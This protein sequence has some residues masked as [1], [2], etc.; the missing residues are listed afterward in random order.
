MEATGQPRSAFTVRLGAAD[1]AAAFL[2]GLRWSVTDP[3]LRW[4]VAASLL[5]NT[6]LFAAFAAALLFGG[7]AGARALLAR[8][9]LPDWLAWL[10]PLFT[11]LGL[12]L[13]APALFQAIGSVA[14]APWRARIFARARVLA[15]APLREG[16]GGIVPIVRVAGTELRRLV[17]LLVIA[18]A[19][20]PLHL[21]P[22]IGSAAYVALQGLASIH[23]LG[24]DLLSY[25][26]ELHD[27]PYAAQREL[28]RR[29]RAAVLAAGALMLGFGLLPLVQLWS[30]SA[31]A[32][33]AGVLSAWLERG[34]PP[35][36]ER[37]A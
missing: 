17:R 8:M 34:V 12:V 18:L 37:L 15:G 23:S 7:W 26:F 16:P 35:R 27:V 36:R 10:V 3:E 28:L 21:V 2:L 32:A 1:A 31:H 5:V 4:R 19:L 25:H 30:L 14:L 24:W 22:G 13:L 9:A 11:L 29:N 33:G 6:L 20:L